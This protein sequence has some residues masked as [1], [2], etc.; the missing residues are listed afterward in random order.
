MPWE[1]DT[2]LG[3][4]VAAGADRRVLV[5]ATA[6][7]AP[8]AAKRNVEEEVARCREQRPRFRDE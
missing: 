1:Q 3:I 5:A 8:G 7:E 4:D 6:T 2:E